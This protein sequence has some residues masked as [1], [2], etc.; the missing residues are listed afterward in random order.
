MIG[1]LIPSNMSRRL[2]SG[3]CAAVLALSACSVQLGS[4]PSTSESTKAVSERDV[5]V[6]VLWY[7]PGTGKGGTS[8]V[9]ITV[10]PSEHNAFRLSSSEA[11]VQ[12]TGDEWKASQWAGSVNAV[13][14][15]GTDPADVTV[16]FEVS[17]RVDGPSAGALMTVGVAAALNGDSVDPSM[18][19]TGT[20][21]PDGSIGPVGGIPEKIQ[22]AKDAGKTRVLI[23]A[24][25]SEA[26]S[27][28]GGAPVD[29]VAEG[30]KLGV[31][32]EEVGDVE[33]AYRKLTGQEM[34]SLPAPV[35]KPDVGNEVKKRLEDHARKWL[36]YYDEFS[37]N[38]TSMGFAA[39]SPGSAYVA[40]AANQAAEAERL[41]SEADVAAAYDAATVATLRQLQGFALDKAQYLLATQGAQAVGQFLDGLQVGQDLADQLKGLFDKKP[42][43][44]TDVA[45]LVGAYQYAVK[46][47]GGSIG[48]DQVLAKPELTTTDLE[49]AARLRVFASVLGE[50][51]T[52]YLELLADIPGPAIDTSIDVA[53]L[54]D[55]FQQGADA[56]LRVFEVGVI[57]Q[58]AAAGGVTPEQAK[59]VVANKFPDYGIALNQQQIVAQLEQEAKADSSAP[60]LSYAKLGAA[61]NNYVTAADLISRFYSLDAQLDFT[62]EYFGTVTDIKNTDALQAMFET[63]TRAVKQGIANLR[64]H[65]VD[66]SPVS[67]LFDMAS[68]E[69]DQAA[70]ANDPDQVLT[71]LQTLW[72]AQITSRMLAYF[73]GFASG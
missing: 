13:L 35:D 52:D 43:T 62:T 70:A 45:A 49:L 22:G 27:E 71:V 25:Q 7:S 51:S 37:T 24:G 54:A 38:Y 40:E 14:A 17:D 41:L 69:A 58:I 67:M 30:K 26:P 47:L 6:Q 33:D 64:S 63:S 59:T 34:V 31:T 20:I 3:T 66:E 56:N 44:V 11:K 61:V 42:A 1:R 5:Q 32:V 60:D 2:V 8:D 16:D 29:V 23:P 39:D 10:K 68:W 36:D 9:D 21:N 46:A 65:N 12:G 48:A 4:G 15:T 53:E 50:A 28:Q 57:S 72:T 18:A 73:G 55:F 19:M